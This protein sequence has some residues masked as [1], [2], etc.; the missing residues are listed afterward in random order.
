MVDQIWKKY[1][2]IVDQRQKPLSKYLSKTFVDRDTLRRDVA[3]A[4]EILE[5]RELKNQDLTHALS[6]DDGDKMSTKEEEVDEPCQ[7]VSYNPS[8]SD[9]I[10]IPDD[11]DEVLIES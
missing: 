11:D 1:D 6:N 8:E 4:N 10:A 5:P 9:D 3:V 7:P 2:L